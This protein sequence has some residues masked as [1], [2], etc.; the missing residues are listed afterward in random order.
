MNRVYELGGA[1]IHPP[2][3][4]LELIFLMKVKELCY[5]MGFPGVLPSIQVRLRKASLALLPQ[6]IFS[7]LKPPHTFGLSG[8]PNRSHFKSLFKWIHLTPAGLP[9]GI[10]GMGEEM[11]GAMQHAP[12]LGRQ[13]I[14]PVSMFG[15]AMNLMI[16]N[17]T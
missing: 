5:C 2:W 6:T 10:P 16:V 9:L 14:Y 4:P 8:E 1:K 17:L 12:H 11:D 3:N 7:A 13:S 15:A